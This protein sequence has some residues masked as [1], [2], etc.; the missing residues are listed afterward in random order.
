MIKGIIS[1]ILLDKFTTNVMQNIIDGEFSAI[2]YMCVPT[3]I[4]FNT[5]FEISIY[6]YMKINFSELLTMEICGAT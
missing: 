4:L 2:W 6:Q 3:Y 5:T 1:L